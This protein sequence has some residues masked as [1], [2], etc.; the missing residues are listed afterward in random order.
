M[1]GR[2]MRAI[3]LM[4][5]TSLD[6]VDAAWIETDG[7]SIGRTGMATTLHYQD[8]LRADLRRLLDLAPAL[9][10]DDPFLLDVERRLTEDH[11]IACAMIGQGAD[12]IGFHGQTILHAPE[13]KF[14]WQIGDTGLLAAR[15]RTKVVYDFRS[16]DV[17]AGGQGAPLVPLF[18]AA[19]AEKLPKPL[20]IVN[21]GGVANMTFLGAGG[22]ILACD[23]GPGNGPLDD[24]LFRHTGQAFDKDGAL[25]S[26]G[27]V[28][29]DQLAMLMAHPY[30]SL[31]APKS[32]DRLTFS[33]L[34]A[35]ATAGL[36]A[37]DG[38]ATLA[39][40]TVAAIAAAPIPEPPRRVLVCG[41]GRK[42]LEIMT[43][44][45]KT[46]AVPVDSVEAVGWD[47]DALEA[48]CFGFLA[49]RSLYGLPLSL[50]GTTGVAAPMPGGR[51]AVPSS[52][53]TP[54]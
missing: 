48:Q 30:F 51:V 37:A 25:A 8:T 12:V 26:Q 10:P 20:L 33:A 43:R 42:N 38:A 11:A 32:L 13:K 28:R 2:R 24:F 14:T 35:Q 36:S 46:F 4:S 6:G 15:T 54:R 40:F 41:G 49:V 50:P 18:H 31:P 27:L 44:L 53:S 45:Q 29:Q 9:A 21:I 1:S 19:L 22:D 16:A 17:A 39:A 5:G 7:E 34:I 47:G 3:G 23:T 52:G